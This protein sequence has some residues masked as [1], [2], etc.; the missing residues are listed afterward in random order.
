MP[1]LVLYD[2]WRSSAAY[3]TRIALHLKGLPFH[4]HPIDLRVGAQRHPSY[5]ARNPQGL[6]PSLEVPGGIVTQSGAILEWLEET[7]PD[8]PL[9]PATPNARAAVRAMAATVGCDIHP[10]NNL[11]VLQALKTS[12][13][14]SEDQVTDWIA[15]WIHNGFE[16]LEPMIA[17]HGGLF[18][19]GDTPT[20][21]DCF[22]VPQVYSAERFKV[23][24]SSFPAICRVAG[25]AKR[26]P[27]FIAAHPDHQPDATG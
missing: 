2:Y 6:V 18:A 16:A 19:Y 17:T 21:A 12:L 3:R 15:R 5:L 24:L 23:A 11:R 8:P 25:R 1:K 10:L 27:S 22:L 13:G 9:L 26:Q 7:Y 20:L 14:A 4:Q